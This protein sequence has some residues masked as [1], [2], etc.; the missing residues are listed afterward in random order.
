MCV[1]MCVCVCMCV[2][3]IQ[4]FVHICIHDTYM[5]RICIQ[6]MYNILVEFFARIFINPCRIHTYTGYVSRDPYR[7]I[8]RDPCI[9]V[10]I[11]VHICMDPWFHI[12]YIYVSSTYMYGSLYIGMCICIHAD[13]INIFVYLY[14]YSIY[15]DYMYAY[16]H[17]YVRIYEEN[18]TFTVCTAKEQKNKKIL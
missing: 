12:L 6:S 7:Y 17:T 1:R 5:Y 3:R 2:Y 4:G 8:S 16:T 13:Y 11:P 15:V 14:I 9:Y 10:W 18:S